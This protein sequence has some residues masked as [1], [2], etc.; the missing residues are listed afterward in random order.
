MKILGGAIRPC[1]PLLSYSEVNAVILRP[2]PFADPGR[3]VMPW[4][5]NPDGGWHQGVATPANMLSW[6]EQVHSSEDV[7]TH[8]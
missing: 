7:A 2:P 8:E 4:E 1:N 6:R 3:P 5:Q